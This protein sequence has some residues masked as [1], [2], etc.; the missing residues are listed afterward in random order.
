MLLMYF[1]NP[2]VDTMLRYGTVVPATWGIDGIYLDL[3]FGSKHKQAVDVTRPCPPIVVPV[4]N[5]VIL[6]LCQP[7]L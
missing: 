5:E 7:Q 6:R 1:P 3:S 2:V 4:L